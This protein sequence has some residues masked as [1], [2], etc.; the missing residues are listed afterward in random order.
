MKKYKFT[1]LK[2]TLH[3]GS[4]YYTCNVKIIYPLVWTGEGLVLFLSNFKDNE[5]Y[6]SQFGNTFSY[7]SGGDTFNL[8][9]DVLKAI[10]KYM[11]KEEEEDGLKIALTETEIIWR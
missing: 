3:N 6:L 2:H 9:E 5:K 7:M 1:I 10:D 11:A 8:R 4:G